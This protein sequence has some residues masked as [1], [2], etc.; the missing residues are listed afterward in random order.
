MSTNAN[1]QAN[2]DQAHL[3][4]IAAG[5]KLRDEACNIH[6]FQTGVP[7]DE[8]SRFCYLSCINS[9]RCSD[10]CKSDCDPETF[11]PPELSKSGIIAEVSA[12]STARVSVTVDGEPDGGIFHVTGKVGLVFSPECRGPIDGEVPACASAALTYLVLDSIGVINVF[13]L[14]LQTV[15]VRNPTVIVG[16]GRA[17][18]PDLQGQSQL[19]LPQGTALFVTAQ[20]EDNGQ[21]A[22]TYAAKAPIIARVNWETRQVIVTGTITAS[23]GDLT[24]SVVLDVVG[25]FDNLAPV[26]AAG[27]E[28]VVECEG[29]NGALVS[30]SAAESR[31]GDGSQD[32]VDFAWSQVINGRPYGRVSG[33]DAAFNVPLGSRS[34]LLEVTDA[35]G[36][37][38][39]DSVT[40]TVVDTTPPTIQ[41]AGAFTAGSCGVDNVTFPVPTVT[42]ACSPD[43]GVTGAVVAIDGSPITPIP[44]AN[45]NAVVPPGRA[46]LRWTA[47][48]AAGN[49]S[50]ID[51]ELVV[52]TGL[53][54]NRRFTLNDRARVQLPT[55]ALAPISNN[56][57]ERVHI[58]VDARVGSI[59][60]IGG[61]SLADRSRVEGF[62][63]SAGSIERQNQS[64]VTGAVTAFASVSLPPF[65]TAQVNFPALPGNVQLE[66]D[67]QLTVQPGGYVNMV[68]KSRAKLF[69]AGGDYYTNVLQ[70]EP[71]SEVILDSG[72]TRLFV[73]N[74][75]IYRGTF[76]PPSGGAFALVLTY[77]GTSTVP[78]ESPFQGTLFAP[79]A[80]LTLGTGGPQQFKGHFLAKEL[81]VRPDTVVTCGLD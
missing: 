80:S 23:S 76:K 26:A 6:Q 10:G 48:D 7:H 49:T 22:R 9:D 21:E 74:S 33:V 41:A 75:V 18:G 37:K 38:S 79:N 36:A 55:G 47:T 81:E 8:A 5:A 24:T 42:D 72:T 20:L 66:P 60:S 63:T 31:D 34:F 62:V 11:D 52:A 28:Q 14:D 78:L 73:R 64:I 16:A 58:G 13:D 77:T 2:A 35:F 50:Q 17:G 19:T 39:N 70:L 59:A 69:L 56:G 1:G 27:A 57:S 46:T 68:I 29:P 67:Q 71:Q 54:A 4:I 65:P 25:S 43:L 32:L 12:D 15:Q 40:A 44:L 51:Q 45:G 61:V 30:L 53:R 3:A